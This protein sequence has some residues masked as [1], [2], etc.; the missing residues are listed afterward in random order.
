ML[1]RLDCSFV[2]IEMSEEIIFG[3][4]LFGYTTLVREGNTFLALAGDGQP[5]LRVGMQVTDL[6]AREITGKAEASTARYFASTTKLS[7]ASPR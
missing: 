7:G 6:D 5:K 2:G 1:L 3:A 4:N